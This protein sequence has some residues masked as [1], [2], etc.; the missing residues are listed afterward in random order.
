M[1]IFVWLT[2]TTNLGNK[3]YWSHFTEEETGNK[4]AVR[5]SNTFIRYTPGRGTQGPAWQYLIWNSSP[6][7]HPAGQVTV[8][9]PSHK[10][11]Y[12][13]SLRGG[14]E[15]LTDAVHLRPCVL[16]LLLHSWKLWGQPE[17]TR[18]F[19][20]WQTVRA[21]CAASLGT[22]PG[23]CWSV[24]SD[25]PSL[26]CGSLSCHWGPPRQQLQS[27]TPQGGKY[28]AGYLPQCGQDRK[29]LPW[30]SCYWAQTL[31]WAWVQHAIQP[32]GLHDQGR[33]L[34]GE[35]ELTWDRFLTTL[36]SRGVDTWPKWG[37]R[38][39]KGTSPVSLC[40][41]ILPAQSPGWS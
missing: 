16:S 15:V 37:E 35:G 24:T 5:L 40:S 20:S 31:S 1:G 27:S 34:C 22:A 36:P 23:S 25:P 29:L 26:A 33:E 4:D 28:V 3:P 41:R 10:V 7:F 8:D 13:D 17:G 11:T 6:P 18:G 2:I 21:I 9:P 12:S 14:V 32:P 19:L 38:C 30:K 39:A